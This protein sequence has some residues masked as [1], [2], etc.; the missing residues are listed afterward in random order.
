MKDYTSVTSS[1]FIF[2]YVLA[3]FGFPKILMSDHGMHF[4]SDTISAMTEEF[5]VYHQKSM[6]SHLQDNG[7][8]EVFNNILEIV[9]MKAFNTERNDWYV[10]IPAVLWAYRTT[11]KKLTRQTPFRLVYGIEAIIPMED[12][13][14]SLHIVTFTRM[15]NRRSM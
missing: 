6:P 11:C 8:V 4:L 15:V 9:L 12:I 1:K 3:R 7:M 10:D 5:Q 14:D 2:E 13:V